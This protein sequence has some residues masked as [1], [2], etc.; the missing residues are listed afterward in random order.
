MDIRGSAPKASLGTGWTCFSCNNHVL[1]HPRFIPLHHIQSLMTD[2]CP[3]PPRTKKNGIH[4]NPH[5]LT[6]NPKGQSP[7]CHG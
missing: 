7:K 1:N 5:S 6:E 3:S 4:R 2:R